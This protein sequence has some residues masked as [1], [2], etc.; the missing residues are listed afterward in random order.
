M[1]KKVTGLF[2]C[3]SKVVTK[4]MRLKLL[5]NAIMKKNKLAIYFLLTF[6]LFSSNIHFI[7]FMPTSSHNTLWCMGQ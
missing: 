6:H 5:T 3:Y 1:L 7:F 2:F 4:L